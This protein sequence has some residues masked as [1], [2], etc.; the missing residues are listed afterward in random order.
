LAA[1]AIGV[2]A[3]Q[4]G[5]HP[6]EAAG[7]KRR[8][9][10]GYQQLRGTGLLRALVPA[11]L[12]EGGNLAATLL[13]LRANQLLEAGGFGA[14]AAVAVST[15]LY[16][17]YNASAALLSVPAGA[18]IDRIGARIVLALGAMSYVIAYIGLAVT[19]GRWELVLLFF[20]FGGAGIGLGETAESTL[21]ARQL[22]DALRGSGFGV[23]GL[24]QAGG[25]LTATVVGGAIF[26]TA[27]AGAAFG[28]AAAW[29]AASAISA[30][31][32]APGAAARA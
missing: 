29:M 22:P 28:Y 19:P 16:A 23:L 9:L 13:I 21:V 24:V 26:A 3:R 7:Q 14:A 8:P 17:A 1:V 4:V 15:V 6:R 27:G 12:F 18:L 2:A 20:V 32:G 25:D 30:I 5:Q 11:A 10:A 31:V